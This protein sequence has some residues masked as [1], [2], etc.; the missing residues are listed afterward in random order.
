MENLITR[1][2]VKLGS[3]KK[4]YLK[5][6]SALVVKSESKVTLTLNKPSYVGMRISDLSKLLMY[7]FHYD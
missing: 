4:D 6:T 3:N 1:I 2:D 5:W 7:K